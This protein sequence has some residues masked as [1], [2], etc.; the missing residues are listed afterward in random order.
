MK[1]HLLLLALLAVQPTRGEINAKYAD[2]AKQWEPAIQAFEKQDREESYPSDSILFMGSSSIRLWTTL[3]RDMAPFHVIQRGYG[4]ARFTD[5][6]VFAGRIVDPHAVRAVVIFVANDI[7]GG[8]TDLA[9]TEIVAL[10]EDVVH[11]VRSKNADAPVFLVAI[12]PTNS[13]WKVWPQIRAANQALR[14]SCAAGDRLHFIATEAQFLDDEGLPKRGLFQDD[15][16]HLSADG[17]AVWTKII[18]ARLERILGTPAP[19]DG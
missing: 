7:V 11:T 9:P 3:A 2:A 8:D 18:R 5:L 19:S 13:R 15:Q 4:G 6:A 16:L 12:T 1:I 17:Y 10:F 14:D